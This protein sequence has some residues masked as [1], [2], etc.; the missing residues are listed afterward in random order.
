LR[1]KNRGFEEGWQKE[2]E[3]L[4]KEERLKK[5]SIKKIEAKEE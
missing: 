4:E 2:E 5:I 1:G 3:R